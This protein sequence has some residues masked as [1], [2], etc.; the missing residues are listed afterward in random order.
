MN[1]LNSSEGA[2]LFNIQYGVC[3]GAI[4]S[5]CFVQNSDSINFSVSNSHLLPFL[6]L[7]LY[8]FLDWLIANF[9][10][11][12][13]RFSIILLLGW[14]LTIWFLGTVIILIRSTYAIKY[15]LVGFYTF[16]I[17]LY[18]LW[19]YCS[20]LYPIDHGPKIV[21]MYFSAPFFLI[22]LFFM[23]QV[24]L[25]LFTEYATET[26]VADILVYVLSGMIFLKY[27]SIWN[28]RV[29]LLRSGQ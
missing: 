10:R 7:L 25:L 23:Y 19:A 8:F 3:F 9:L 21:G 5:N 1:N 27:L 4:F 15:G 16:Y 18:Q 26:E 6:A 24:Y 17:G 20:K 22:G 28:L 13:I 11:D 12:K 29:Q 2:N 14:S